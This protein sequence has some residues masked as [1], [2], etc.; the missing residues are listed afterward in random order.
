MSLDA[1]VVSLQVKIQEAQLLLTPSAFA[2]ASAP[3]AS[4][5]DARLVDHLVFGS[6]LQTMLMVT[7]APLPAQ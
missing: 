3:F 2:F 4:L 7:Y 5:L 6:D 1:L